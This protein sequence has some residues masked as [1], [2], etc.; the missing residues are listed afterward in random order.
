MGF[1]LAR[2]LQSTVRA[3]MINSRGRLHQHLQRQGRKC[4]IATWQ[5][6]EFRHYIDNIINKERMATID[7]IDI[8][9]KKADDNKKKKENNNKTTRYIQCI[10]KAHRK[11]SSTTTTSTEV[12]YNNDIGRGQVPQWHRKRSS[13]RMTSTEVKYN[14]DIDRG[15]VH[16]V[17]RNDWQHHCEEEC[18]NDIHREQGVHRQH[19]QQ[20]AMII[21][22]DNIDK[23][24][25]GSTLTLSCTRLRVPPVA[26]HVSRYTCR[27]WFPGFHSVLQV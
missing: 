3:W 24:N 4:M 22:E 12:K 16:Q 8:V 21:L 13:T 6:W 25:P 11:R 18:D 14:K 9:N 26:L 27:S 5:F 7:N 23:K 17:H 15:Q 2:P 20:E 1:S 10:D 19:R